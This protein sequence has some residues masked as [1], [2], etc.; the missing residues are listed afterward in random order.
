[1]EYINLST[2]DINE[3]S[4]DL[5]LLSSELKE[6]LDDT[7]NTLDSMVSKN[8]IWLG[9]SAEEFRKQI[10]IDRKDYIAFR[11]Q[12]NKYSAFLSDY[13]LEMNKLIGVLKK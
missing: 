11:E 6:I 12:L 9:H 3:C 8:N 10:L 13:S 5:S 4:K 7:F 1:M 2:S